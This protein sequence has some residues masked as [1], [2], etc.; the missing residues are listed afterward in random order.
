MLAEFYRLIC[1]LLQDLWEYES[2]PGLCHPP[3]WEPPAPWAQQQD[4]A[5]AADHGAGSAFLGM[6]ALANRC[7]AMHDG[8][9]FSTMGMSTHKAQLRGHTD[10]TGQT[11]TFT[12]HT[13]VARA[14]HVVTFDGQVWNLS[15]QCRSIVLAQDFTH[16]TFSLMLSQT[17]LGL[18]ALTV[19]MNHV[20]LIFYS[21]LKASPGD[22]C[23]QQPSCP[24]A[25]RLYSFSLRGDSCPDL[26]LPFAME[27]RDIPRIELASEDGVSITCDVPT[28]LCSLTVSLWHHGESGPQ[29]SWPH[30]QEPLRDAPFSAFSVTGPRI[31]GGHCG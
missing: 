16:N 23:L 13:L 15:I 28:G 29:Q 9:C 24:P 8:W 25:C 1:H 20:P 6:L 3:P 21:S 2:C 11:C 14:Q 26:Q 7:L 17:G 18:M 27:R 22:L 5:G 31:V 30:H 12:D 19:E 4:H 10:W